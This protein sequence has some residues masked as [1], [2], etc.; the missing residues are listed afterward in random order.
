VSCSVPQQE[1]PGSIGLLNRNIDGNLQ[2][3]SAELLQLA[4]AIARVGAIICDVA[5]VAGGNNSAGKF[6]PAS[7]QPYI[8]D[9]KED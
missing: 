4:C 9:M 1:Y 7:E 2:L 3:R 8:W 6:L 5:G